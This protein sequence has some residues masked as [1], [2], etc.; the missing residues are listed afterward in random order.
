M[1][2]PGFVGPSYVSQSPILATQR[3]VNW[4]LESS[5]VGD[6][7]FQSALY[8]TPGCEERHTFDESPV[9]GMLEHNGRCFVVV[10]QTFYEL[11]NDK[12][13]TPTVRGTVARNVDPATLVA[14]DMGD[15]I[16]ITSAGVGYV[17]TL[18][19]NAFATVLASGATQGEFLDGFFLS[20]NATTSTL[21]LSDLNDGTTWDVTQYAQRTA[22]ADPWQSVVVTHR[23]I[24]LFGKQT[25]EVWYNAGTSPFPFAA[26]PGAFL[27]QGIAAP[28]SAKRLGNTII[29][30]GSSEE[31]D[32]V[33][34][35]ANGYTP[36]RIST[37][38]VE[39]AIQGYVRAGISITDAVAWTYQEDGHSF[40]GLNFPS[41]KATWVFD[42]ATQL[43]HERGTWNVDDV[44]YKAWR[45]QYHVY[46]FSKHLV[47]D[48]ALG[49]VYEMSIEKFQD[50]GGGPLRR[51]RRT[52]HVSVN[53]DWMFYNSLQ[54]ELQSGLGVS[55]GQGSDPQVMMRWSDDGGE[56]WGNEHWAS[57]GKRG[58]YG[59]RTIWRRLGR[60][61]DR[62]YE[63]AVSDPI[64]WRVTGA[65]LE[66]SVR[67]R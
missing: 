34:W 31:G 20:L 3:C 13:I 53:D 38:A 39:F 15:E 35:M 17:F 2:F 30:L 57:A 16:F 49:T 60:G 9:R 11:Y 29:W 19:T 61:Y 14:N 27:E 22:G 64:P 41:A 59:V 12:T 36:Q 46:A 28:Y 65:Y 42:A 37:H 24:W 66:L 52:P 5:E 6:E 62:V 63:I 33:V 32:G 4:Y 43:W 1:K 10:G 25:T 40:Y 48:R 26:I 21:R 58:N 23:D 54:V 56:T 44:E 45:P 8:P 67:D 51:L 47:G 55:A 50:A 18:S 7:P